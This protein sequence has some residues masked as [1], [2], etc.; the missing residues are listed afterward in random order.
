[1]PKKKMKT[2]VV[3]LKEAE[4]Y[5]KQIL[6]DD[7]GWKDTKGE[8]AT[9]VQYVF[10][11]AGKPIGKT[12]TWKQGAKVKGSSAKPGTAI[13]SFRDGKYQDDHAAILIKETADGLEVWDQFKNPSKPWGKRTLP[14]DYKGD[15]PYSNDGDKFSIIETESK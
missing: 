9:G 10:S 1:M 11:K 5:D 4:K 15:S 3:S 14:F 2:H 13:A 12:S 8:C 7:D 6:S